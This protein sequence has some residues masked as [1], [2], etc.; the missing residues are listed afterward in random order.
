VAP[1]CV[2]RAISWAAAALGAWPWAFGIHIEH[3]LLRAAARLLTGRRL[4][5]CLGHRDRALQARQGHLLGQR[6]SA[7]QHLAPLRSLW[8]QPRRDRPLH[9]WNDHGR[10]LALGHS[11]GVV[12]RPRVL[13]SSLEQIRLQQ[14]AF[15]T[16]TVR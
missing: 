6:E 16:K 2:R 1:H 14:R 15:V 12:D 5:R 10:Y 9:M 7:L 4:L 13:V 8:D 3:A 11:D